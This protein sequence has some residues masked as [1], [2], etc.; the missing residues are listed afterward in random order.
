VYHS[1]EELVKGLDEDNS[2]YN[3][4][5]SK[6]SYDGKLI[7]LSDMQT[8][9]RYDDARQRMYEWAENRVDDEQMTWSDVEERLSKP[10]LFNDPRAGEVGATAPGEYR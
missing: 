1:T 8:R 10:E 6:A 7:N 9:C 2:M 5:Q 4:S 3:P